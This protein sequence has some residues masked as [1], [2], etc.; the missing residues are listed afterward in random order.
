MGWLREAINDG[1]T[2][3]ASSKRIVMLMGGAALSVSVVVLS[4]AALFGHPVA[5]ELG[6][7]SVPLAGLA[8]YSYVNGKQ[9][10]ANRA[11]PA[12]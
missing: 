9:V 10:E 12:A 1:R 5:G 7:V 3:K 2:G 8:G 11:A 6:A 4:V